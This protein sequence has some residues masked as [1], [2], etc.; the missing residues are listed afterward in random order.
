MTS[1]EREPARASTGILL[2]GGTGF[3]GG[4]LRA[5]L[6]SYEVVLLGRKEPTDLTDNERWSHMDMADW[7]APED[8]GEGEVL[9]H[10]AYSVA[11][12][13]ENI[14]YNQ[15]LLDAVNARPGIKRVIL[16]SST[17]VYGPSA[18]RVV[19]ERIPCS[20]TR[21]TAREKNGGEARPDST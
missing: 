2:T 8:L 4:H 21:N 6:Q 1:S 19:D 5:A 9:C 7:V 20:P 18:E 13:R 16:L 3:V 17:S 15:C 11:D 12:G 10:L 14:G